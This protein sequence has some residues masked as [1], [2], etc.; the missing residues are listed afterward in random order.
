MRFLVAIIFIMAWGTVQAEEYN[1]GIRR[2]TTEVADVE[3]PVRMFYPTREEAIEA[4]FGPWELLAARNALPMQGEFPLVAISH[5]LGGN[6]W[7][8]RSRILHR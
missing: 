7:N 6:D 8:H 1:V 3:I 4:K 2:I 5:G